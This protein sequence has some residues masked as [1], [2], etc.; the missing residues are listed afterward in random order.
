MSA[1]VLAQ[2]QIDEPGEYQ[3]YLAGFMPIFERHVFW[4]VQPGE[5]WFVLFLLGFSFGRTGRPVLTFRRKY[6]QLRIRS[7]SIEGR[8]TGPWSR[9]RPTL[10][11][12]TSRRRPADHAPAHGVRGPANP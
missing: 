8:R 7:R 3:K 6:A 5:F 1:Y 12:A 10:R 4:L 11:G 2:I 9:P